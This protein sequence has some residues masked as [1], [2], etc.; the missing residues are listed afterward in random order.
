V[1]DAINRD[2]PFD[3][4]IREQIAGDLLTADS[5]NERSRQFVATGFLAI[6]AKAL[7]EQN[8]RQ[9]ALDIADEQI[10]AVSQSFLGMT[11]ACARCHDHKF[12]PVS[13]KEYTALAGIFLSTDTHYGTT[14]AVGGR[15]AAKLLELP[16]DQAI[17][18]NKGLSSKE[19]E[20]KKSRIAT[21]EEEREEALRARRAD[22]MN[23]GNP[24]PVVDL[25]RITTQLAVLKTELEAYDEYGNPKRLAMGV[26]DRPATA[27][28]VQTARRNRQP[29]RPRRASTFV[30]VGDSP[31]FIRGET[32]RPSETVP[33]GFPTLLQSVE[34]P[35][36]SR[37][38]SGRLQL[39]D[40]I[41]D[42]RNP[43]TSRVVVN[44]VWHW[45][46]G[47]GIV[48]SVDNFGTT[49]ALPSHPEL[50]DY[51]AHDFVSQGWSL[52]Q[53]IREIVN[54]R[55]Y[56]L[57]TQFDERS[58]QIDPSNALLWR[59]SPK[60]LEAEVIR[61]SML[62]AAG[63][64]DLKPPQGSLIGRSGD[65]VIDNRRRAGISESTIS[66]FD[67]RHRSVYLPAARGV[68]SSLLGIFNAPDGD[69]VQGA[70]EITNVPSQALYLMNSTLVTKAAE[71]ISR[72]VFTEVRG[73]KPTAKFDDVYQ[74]L[75]W[76]LF[77]R[78]ALDR[79]VLQAKKLFG[80]FKDKPA[81]GYAAVTR[82]MLGAAEFR[83]SD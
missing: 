74:E 4:F 36:I 43:L 42:P 78:P 19:L 16:G 55:T 22:R 23:A 39:A 8:P 69:V 56:R 7:N 48:T 58:F 21:L 49:G 79:E 63:M 40:W 34:A 50:L 70:R 77:G 37:S 24:Q 57:S 29:E 81:K 35:S 45:L 2:I 30:S 1:I 52:K 59:H 66:A 10:D 28:R 31:L 61:D 27:P 38:E 76:T 32:N 13:Q 83:S 62:Q 44:R 3:Q 80:R 64:L 65:G 11:F 72:R 47:A 53:L 68:E 14:G 18:L 73:N 20:Q 26:V 33:R 17:V 6:G 25:Q 5:D 15:N 9:L 54:S 75:S 67:D 82:A 41:A 51:L 60:R 71:A 12:D 46:F